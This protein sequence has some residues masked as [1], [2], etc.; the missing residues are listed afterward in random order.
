MGR[1][2]RQKQKHPP[3][4]TPAERLR[5]RAGEIFPGEKTL[6]VSTPEGLPKMSDVLIE[7]AQPLLA[8]ART[9][10]EYRGAFAL[11]SVAWNLALMPFLKR[12]KRLG[13]LVKRAD[14]AAADI[15]LDLIRRKHELFADDKRW[16][17]DFEI[18]SR[19][20]GWGHINVLWTIDPEELDDEL[21]ERFLKSN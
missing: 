14:R 19:R 1:A 12:L 20:G 4:P 8:E 16:V 17:L 21:L 11:A 10:S 7:F 6:V 2:S 3:E 15:A 9:E 5:R 18:S 13:E